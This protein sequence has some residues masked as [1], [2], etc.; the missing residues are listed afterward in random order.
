M[1]HGD[2]SQLL[3]FIRKDNKK[4]MIEL[5]GSIQDDLLNIS[6]TQSNILNRTA[7]PTLKDESKIHTDSTTKR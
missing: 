3:D 6:K 5:A 7:S 1:Y 4:H 2:P